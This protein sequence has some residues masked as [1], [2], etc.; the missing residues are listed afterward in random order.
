MALEGF[1]LTPLGRNGSTATFADVTGGNTVTTELAGNAMMLVVND[2]V[3][4]TKEDLR[5]QLANLV[6]DV[7]RRLGFVNT[8]SEITAN[9]KVGNGKTWKW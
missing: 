6:A 7:S 4:N 8:P 1:K 5:N 3:I 9:T 2:A